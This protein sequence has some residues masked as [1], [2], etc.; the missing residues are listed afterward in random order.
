MKNSDS[1]F[2]VGIL[3]YQCRCVYPYLNDEC[4][5][6]DYF[7]NWQISYGKNVFYL[8]FFTNTLPEANH[9]VS[10]WRQVS[11]LK[12]NYRA[13]PDIDLAVVGKA[14]TTICLKRN[15]S[16]AANYSSVDSFASTER[17]DC[18]L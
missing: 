3:I 11:R 2:R 13:S 17:N 6:R 8:L 4:K 15:V 9:S 18:L 7:R 1:P 5:V 10:H 16:P 12:G 14:L